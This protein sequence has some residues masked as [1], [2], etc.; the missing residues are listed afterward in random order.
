MKYIESERV[1]LKE[2]AKDELV[3]EIVAF[4]NAD[5]GTIYIGVN[6]KGEVVGVANIDKELLK[7]ADMITQQ[8]EPNPQELVKPELLFDEGKTIIA[9]PP[10][11]NN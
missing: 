1:E 7:I 2:H 5:G 10:G 3:K 8:I 9:I 11:A 4:L 6:D